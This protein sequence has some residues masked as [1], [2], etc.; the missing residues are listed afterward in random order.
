MTSPLVSI[1]IP[2]Y[3][4]AHCITQSIESALA[5][6][7]SNLEIVIADDG[8]SDNT[9]EVVAAI[10][11]S[12]VRYCSQ[13][14]RGCSSARNLGVS[15]ARGEYLA[16]LDSDDRWEP[17]WVGTAVDLLEHHSDFGSAYASLRRIGAQ[18]EELGTL[19]LSDGGQWTEGTVAY[20]L[21]HCAG[22]LG[23]NVIARSGVVRAIGGWDEGFPTSGDLDFGLRLAVQARM[24]LFAQPFVHLVETRGS[25]SKNINTGNRLRVLAKFEL[26]YS[27]LAAKHGDILRRSRS[28]ILCN[29]GEDLLWSGQI[30][31]AQGQL[32]E[33]LRTRPNLPALWLLLK[34]Q[35]LKFRPARNDQAPG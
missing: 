9:R 24:A 29:Y 23:S 27:H 31:R 33:S 5:Q 10:A 28:R 22:L 18:G 34:A 25:L 12:R 13:P 35:L 17:G 4:R 1:I 8:S 3:N 21:S 15:H 2:T 6:H 7:Y 16:F 14:N 30:S 32:I 11:D 26:L 19:D 20:V